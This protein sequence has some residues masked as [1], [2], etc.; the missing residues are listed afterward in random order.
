[1][2]KILASVICLS[3]FL[4]V[5]SFSATKISM[6]TKPAK[7]TKVTKAIKT[8]KTVTCEECSVLKE[9]WAPKKKSSKITTD[10]NKVQQ[11]K[12]LKQVGKDA[13]IEPKKGNDVPQKSGRDVHPSTQF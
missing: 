6:S 8:T 13:T 2:K 1:M 12:I 3:L 5:A 9:K 7:D 4:S 10:K 11:T